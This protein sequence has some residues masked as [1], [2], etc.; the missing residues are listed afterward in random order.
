VNTSIHTIHLDS[1]FSKHELFRESVIPYLE[2]NRLRPRVHANQKTRP[3]A[4]CAKVL[5]RALLAVRT[6]VNS[7]WMILSGHAEVAFPSTTATT[8]TTTAANF[9]TLAASTALVNL[10][11]SVATAAVTATNV[12]NTSG[13]LVPLLLLVL[14]L[15]YKKSLSLL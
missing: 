8:T 1:H 11:P 14:S 5:G 7:F 15:F 9:P 3:I 6:D 10:A 4:Y 12:T 13:C 2:T